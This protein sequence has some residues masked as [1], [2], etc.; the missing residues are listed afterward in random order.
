MKK[1][2][3]K[4]KMMVTCWRVLVE[5]KRTKTRMAEW[6]R[7]KRTI[8][9]APVVD[10]RIAASEG[11]VLRETPATTRKAERRMMMRRKIESWRRVATEEFVVQDRPTTKT[12]LV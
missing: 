3:T 10:S 6:S 5:E 1:K 2:K 11:F 8:I 12:K 9:A 4:A 7:R